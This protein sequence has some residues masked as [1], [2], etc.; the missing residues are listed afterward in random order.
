MV[1]LAKLSGQILWRIES[2]ILPCLPLPLNKK[3][4][5]TKKPLNKKSEM[6]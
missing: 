5:I 6:Q 4:E 3:Y 1:I 2:T